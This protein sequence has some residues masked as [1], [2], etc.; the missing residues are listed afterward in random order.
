MTGDRCDRCLNYTFGFDK[1]LGCED[2]DCHQY[3]VRNR[4]LQCD[5]VTGQCNCKVNVV[6]RT[7]NKCKPGIC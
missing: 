6:G 5:V 4:D 2:C 3:G 1:I 7:C